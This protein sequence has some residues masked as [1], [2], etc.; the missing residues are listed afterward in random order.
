[1]HTFVSPHIIVLDADLLKI[2][3]IILTLKY[4][5]TVEPTA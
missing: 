5:V 2:L 1:M 4:I 3:L